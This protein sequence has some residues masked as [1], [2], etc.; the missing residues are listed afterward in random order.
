MLFTYTMSHHMERQAV[1]ASPGWQTPHAALVETSVPPS[2]L[3]SFYLILG[4]KST[5]YPQSVTLL[6]DMVF[7]FDT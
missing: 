7:E 3:V 5:I 6:S 1:K 4:V 2:D